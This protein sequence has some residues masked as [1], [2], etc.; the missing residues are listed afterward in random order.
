MNL[1]PGDMEHGSELLEHCKFYLSRAY[2]ELQNGCLAEA[3]RWIEEYRR[4]RQEL[5]ELIKRKEEHDKLLQVVEM[6]KARGIDIAIIM[7]G[8]G[9]DENR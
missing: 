2:L 3:D 7:R 8:A 5:D 1:L 6:M 9:C 4:C